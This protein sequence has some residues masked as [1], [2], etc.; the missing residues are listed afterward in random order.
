MAESAALKKELKKMKKE[1]T[2]KPKEVIIEKEK[3]VDINIK[4]PKSITAL[5]KK[6]SKRLSKDDD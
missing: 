4:V 3:E 1:L 6:L 5:E 2:K